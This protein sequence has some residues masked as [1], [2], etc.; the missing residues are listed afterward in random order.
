MYGPLLDRRLVD[1]L[2]FDWLDAESLLESPRFADHSAETVGAIVDLASR[3]AE[4]EF[5]PCYQTGD[6]NEPQLRADGVRIDP[7]VAAAVRAF[8]DA[9]LSSGPFDAELDGMQLP[10]TVHAVVMAHFMAANLAASAY[11]MLSIANARL[12]AAFGSP[13]QVERFAKPQIAGAMLGT[14][15]LSEPQ[16]GSSLADITTR[17]VAD[18]ET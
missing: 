6:R 15:C 16:A 18:G 5:L 8:C 2:M 9:G 3:I 10:E 11:P 14:M 1:F 12:I 4:N 17:A 13:T 7:D